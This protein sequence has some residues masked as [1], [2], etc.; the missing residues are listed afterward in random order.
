M[1]DDSGVGWGVVG[2]SDIVE[3]RA[4]DAI[5]R[6]ARSRLVAFHSRARARAEAFA[7]AFG[8]PAA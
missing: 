6:Q 2:C 8:A 4:G 1:S 7:A 5:R 3:R